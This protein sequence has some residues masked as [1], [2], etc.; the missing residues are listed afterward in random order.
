MRE[1]DL[2]A[3]RRS[4]L[5]LAGTY[6]TTGMAM[7]SSLIRLNGRQASLGAVKSLS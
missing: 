7:M 2:R 3:S 6:V 5:C 4:P 1:V